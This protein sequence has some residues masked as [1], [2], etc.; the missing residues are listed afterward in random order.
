MSDLLRGGRLS[1]VRD[2][3]IKFTSSTENDKWLFPSI[4]Q[5]NQAHIIMLIEQG[6]IKR[7]E[8]ASLLK[9]LISIELPTSSSV[10]DLH[11]YVEEQVIAAT[12]EQIGGNLHIAKSRND[13]VATAIRMK[14]RL[15]LLQIVDQI[16][17]LQETYL[18]KST[19]HY[20]TII[21]GYTHLQPAQPI[22]YAHYLLA[23]ND[24]LERN[25]YRI[26]DLYSRVDSCPMGAGALATT[27]FSIDR[28]RVATLLG[29]PE[30]LENSLDAVG[31]R[32]FILEALSTLTILANDLSRFVE[33]LIL[34]SSFNFNL[35]ELPDAFTSTS[36]IMPQKKNPDVLEVIRS[37]TSMILGNFVTVASTLKSLPSS[38]NLDHQEITPKLWD[39]FQL[40]SSA[41]SMFNEINVHLQ[42]KPSLDV[43]NSSYS[44]A[45]E[46]ANILVRNYKVPFRQAHKV[47][48]ALIKYLIDNQISISEITEVTLH[49]FRDNNPIMEGIHIQANEVQNALDPS[50]FII[51]HNVIG[52]PAPDET[53]RMLQKRNISLIQS[54]KWVQDRDHNL[55][56]ALEKLN[57]TI[58]SILGKKPSQG[59]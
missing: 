12:N 29:F 20:T 53:K 19:S 2:D 27:S 57:E 3:V 48:G 54:K 58:T 31:S 49:N 11:M 22:T 45:T 34:W 50:N 36:S 51:R 30:I 9:S 6:I 59:P 28:Q 26:R 17:T 41:L 18:T 10:E 4:L 14:L 23:C 46:L 13:Q 7:G 40:L 44:T 52:G 43:V 24:I 37:R 55:T 1:S 35:L 38:Y 56:T 32:D 8:G 21:P 39:S 42:L 16:L 47:V 5:I 25:V 33:D 15:E